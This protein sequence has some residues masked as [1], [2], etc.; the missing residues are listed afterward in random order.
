MTEIIVES[1]TDLPTIIST[2]AV[3][4]GLDAQK[5]LNQGADLVGVARA[6][7]GH[8]NWAR[9]A[10]DISYNPQKPPY[11]RQ[12]L[13]DKKLSDVFIDYMSHWKDFVIKK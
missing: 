12:Y 8:P 3:W 1:Y 11:T 4:S 6:G 7:I 5:L 13:R 10:C 2:G 9:M